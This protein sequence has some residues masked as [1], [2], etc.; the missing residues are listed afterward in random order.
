MI[1]SRRN[2]NESCSQRDSTD[3]LSDL[4]ERLRSLGNPK[5]LEGMR[6]YG[7]KT[8]SA[9]GVSIP[10]LRKV[11]REVG[12]NHE[13]ALILWQT[14][15]HDARLLAGI[16]DIPSKVTESQMEEWAS[17]FDSWDVVDGT[18]GNLF[19][20]SEFAI[21]KAHQ[22]AD[23]AE[24]YV[25]R[26][27]FVL[28]AELAVHDKK[29]SDK[30]FLDFLPTLYDGALDERNFVKKAVNWALRQIGKRNRH[31]N[32]AAISTSNRI[33]K[34]DS[35]AARWIASDALRELTSMKVQ[36]RLQK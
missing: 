29:T 25:K 18:C 17:D 6:R 5:D 9:F 30:T 27:G 21:A 11:G 31:L 28:M 24:E 32:K 23:R 22:W 4:I 12:K 10:K 15:L 33:L 16:I 8:D 14:G 34:L 3:R 7:I 20:K 13:L 26:A 35:R 2:N 19:D 36:K 1:Q